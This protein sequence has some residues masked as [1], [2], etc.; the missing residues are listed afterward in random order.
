MSQSV[1][2]ASE[3][4]IHC[5]SP[6]ALQQLS[7]SGLFD[8]VREEKR[9]LFTKSLLAGAAA[10]AWMLLTRFQQGPKLNHRQQKYEKAESLWLRTAV[11][12]K[13]VIGPDC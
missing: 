9:K 5:K 1:F 11:K 4:W 13:E 10:A 8:S 2:S 6:E 3:K 12:A 7:L